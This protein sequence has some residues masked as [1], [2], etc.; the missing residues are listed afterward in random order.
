MYSP[1]WALCIIGNIITQYIDSINFNEN[2]S[3]GIVFHKQ[4]IMK[5]LL[6]YIYRKHLSLLLKVYNLALYH[7][8][9]NNFVTSM[10][11]LRRNT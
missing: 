1:N 11:Q 7:G 9:V 5:Q 4:I 6:I 8:Q 2:G 3:K 10:T